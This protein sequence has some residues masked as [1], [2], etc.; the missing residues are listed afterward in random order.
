MFLTLKCHGIVAATTL[1]S[2]CLTTPSSNVLLQLCQCDP[3]GND[4]FL[5]LLHFQFEVNSE[6]IFFFENVAC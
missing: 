1:H 6:K 5:Y 4:Q 3:V 2:L